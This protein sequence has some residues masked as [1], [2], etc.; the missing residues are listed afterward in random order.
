MGTKRASDIV[1]LEGSMGVFVLSQRTISNLATFDLTSAATW[2]QHNRYDTHRHNITGEYNQ[3]DHFFVSYKAQKTVKK[4]WR[5]VPL[6]HSDHLPVYI[7]LRLA[8]YIPP[9]VTYFRRKRRRC[10]NTLFRRQKNMHIK[11][12]PKLHSITYVKICLLQ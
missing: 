10:K 11:S 9:K 1:K 4:C 7:S 2:F 5:G 12:H 3:L 6:T 8:H